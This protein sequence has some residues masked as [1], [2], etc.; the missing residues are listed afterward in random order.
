M[1]KILKVIGILAGVFTMLFISIGV[2][3]T[4]N[5]PSAASNTATVHLKKE[6]ASALNHTNDINHLKVGQTVKLGNIE[7]TL[8]SARTWAGND[9][10][11]PQYGKY[12][13]ANVTVKNVTNTIQTFYGM[14]MFNLKDLHGNVKDLAVISTEKGSL[15][16][17][18]QPEGFLQGDIAFDVEKNLTSF[19]F[20]V[21]NAS[22]GTT[23]AAYA[24]ANVK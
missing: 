18:I 4:L 21:Q 22:G 20:S 2:I 9:L 11:K 12:V 7:I 8:N 16:G 10:E 3:S 14:E 1:K 6:T 24:I 19:T 15:E 13:I 5:R 23:Q 17:D